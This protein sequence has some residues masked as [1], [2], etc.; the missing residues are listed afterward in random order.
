VT[1]PNLLPF[2]EEKSTSI[3]P[4]ALEFRR[5]PD[6]FAWRDRFIFEVEPLIEGEHPEQIIVPDVGPDGRSHTVR[7]SNADK[8]L[9][10]IC[11]GDCILVEGRLRKVT[12]IVGRKSVT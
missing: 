4:N 6:H 1:H 2:P 12:K 8:S 9:K 7:H 10:D 5:N 11:I 3:D